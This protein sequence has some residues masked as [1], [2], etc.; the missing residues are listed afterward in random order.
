MMN[1]SVGWADAGIIIPYHFWKQYGDKG[2]LT[3]Y[4]DRMKHYAEFMI[5][6][7]GKNAPLCKP[8]KV[9]GEDRKYIVNAGQSYGEWAEPADVFPNDWTNCV[10]PHPE[11]STA[12]TSYVLGLM[13]K[14]AHEV[15]NE[16][17]EKRYADYSENCK[18]AYRELV[19]T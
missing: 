4:Y 8:H 18:N 5:S 7:I 2:I 19:K 17:D 15:G 1:G 13:S 11:V 12:Y 10:F 3:E 9:K 14:I 6:R 16:A